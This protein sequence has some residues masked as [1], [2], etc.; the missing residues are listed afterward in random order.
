MLALLINSRANSVFMR[1]GLRVSVVEL[2]LNR[3]LEAEKSMYSAMPRMAL[4]RL[5]ILGAI[6]SPPSAVAHSS[7]IS[8]DLRALPI[9]A[10]GTSVF[11]P[12]PWVM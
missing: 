8:V 9:Q 3:M 1:M 11:M 10:T 4:M 12:T 2:S 7:S 6:G 5:L